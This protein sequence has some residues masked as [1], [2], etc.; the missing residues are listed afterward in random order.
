M[1]NYDFMYNDN[2]KPKRLTYSEINDLL[3]MTAAQKYNLNV[4]GLSV[5][6]LS[7]RPQIWRHSCPAVGVTILKPTYVMLA[8]GTEIEYAIC[9]VCG[10]ITFYKYE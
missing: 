5:I 1:Y 3:L 9:P 2:R 8:D 10:K 7:D 6:R 4:M